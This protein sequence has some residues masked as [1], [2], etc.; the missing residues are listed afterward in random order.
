MRWHLV[1]KSDGTD[2]AGA[3]DR[4]ACENKLVH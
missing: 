3:G 1:M 2:G 4:V